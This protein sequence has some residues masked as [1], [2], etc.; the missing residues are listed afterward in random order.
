M[1]GC[2]ARLRTGSIDGV[3]R[4]GQRIP[5]DSTCLRASPQVSAPSQ[6]VHTPPARF[7]SRHAPCPAQGQVA[8][9]ADFDRY[10][11]SVPDLV[12]RPIG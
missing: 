10:R 12:A 3:N 4:S 5:L 1:K 6:Q 2:A 8:P 7:D 11:A 9:H